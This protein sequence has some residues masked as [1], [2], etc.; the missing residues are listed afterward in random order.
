MWWVA[1]AEM[2]VGVMIVVVA[3]AV[4]VVL[5]DV[6]PFGLLGAVFLVD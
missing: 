5:L 3:V 1:K 4:A 2:E 6:L